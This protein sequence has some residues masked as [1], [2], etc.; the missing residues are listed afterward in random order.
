[1]SLKTTK[2]FGCGCLCVLG[3]IVAMVFWWEWYIHYH[4]VTVDRKPGGI[5]PLTATEIHWYYSFGS[6]YYE[7]TITVDD[8]LQEAKKR[9]WKLTPIP[10]EEGVRI[11]CFNFEKY[12][13][14]PEITRDYFYE[15]VVSHGYYEEEHESLLVYDSDAQRVYFKAWR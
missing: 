9:R 7:Y 10:P 11:H 13:E 14:A 8:F 4:V 15:K 3:I 1:M 12:K 5:A 6:V 2:K